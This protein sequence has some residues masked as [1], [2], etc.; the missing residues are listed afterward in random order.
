[1]TLLLVSPKTFIPMKIP[2]KMYSVLIN[3]WSTPYLIDVGLLSWQFSKSSLRTKRT[4]KPPLMP[5]E[6]SHSLSF[7]PFNQGSTPSL[8]PSNKVHHLFDTWIAFDY[9]F[10]TQNFFVW[11]TKLGTKLGTG[12]NSDSMLET[13]ALQNGMIL[14]ALNVNSHSFTF[15][16][17]K[18]PRTN[19]DVFLTYKPM[20]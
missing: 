7:N 10:E 8:K 4:I 2:I 14:F 16:F 17:P 5:I 18:M 1:M 15:S 13:T 6:P 9:I 12:Y 3:P 20:I 11:H 19:G